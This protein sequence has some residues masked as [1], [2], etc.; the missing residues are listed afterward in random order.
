MKKIHFISNQISWKH[1]LTQHKSD[2]SLLSSFN[3]PLQE[4]VYTSSVSGQSLIT[5]YMK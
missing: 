3:K 1:P 2:L 5:V 4:G